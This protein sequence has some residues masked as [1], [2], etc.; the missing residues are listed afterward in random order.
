VHDLSDT[1]SIALE[2]S[3]DVYDRS[4]VSAIGDLLWRILQ[5][6]GH[7]LDLNLVRFLKSVR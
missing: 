6:I 2:Y 5:S 3:S 1:M 7:S 4:T